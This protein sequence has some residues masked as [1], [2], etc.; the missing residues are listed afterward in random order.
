MPRKRKNKKPQI[1]MSLAEFTQACGVKP[2]TDGLPTAP[3]AIRTIDKPKSTMDD[4]QNWRGTRVSSSVREENKESNGAD[5]DMN[6]RGTR[7]TSSVRE[8]NKESNGAD[9]DMNWRKVQPKK[10][11]KSN[12]NSNSRFSRF[13]RGGN[14]R[15]GNSHGGN[16]HGGFSSFGNNSESG[17]MNSFGS[18]RDSSHRDSP[19]SDFNSF[20]VKRNTNGK[21]NS[22]PRGRG[23]FR[24]SER[25]LTDQ[26]KFQAALDERRILE[27]KKV[28]E[29]KESRKNRRTKSKKKIPV[30]DFQLDEMTEED[31]E[32]M[33]AVLRRME[34]EEAAE[35]ET[36]DSDNSN[37]EQNYI[38]EV[39]NDIAE[40]MTYNFVDSES[41]TRYINGKEV[42]Y[43][44]GNHW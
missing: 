21:R 7:V 4:K 22:A 24:R 30:E 10:P 40:S 34:E 2:E 23:R 29:R 44:S 41:S 18:H 13:S 25:E 27:E 37:S 6:W 33:K 28:S 20:R 3:S 15:G 11:P 17:P 12:S 43:R 14:S 42:G 38:D 26:E 35:E 1:R 32:I 8:E 5:T 31:R 36:S 19:G 39:K 9:T 16:S